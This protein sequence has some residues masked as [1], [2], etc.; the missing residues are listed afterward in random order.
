MYDSMI[1]HTWISDES[2]VLL[3][4]EITAR[5]TYSYTDKLAS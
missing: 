3:P 1:N 5:L 2:A 4:D